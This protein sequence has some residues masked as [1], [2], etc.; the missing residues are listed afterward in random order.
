MDER[1]SRNPRAVALAALALVG[2][3]LA[4]AIAISRHK[5]DQAR[6]QSCRANLKYM[7]FALQFYTTDWDGRL[8]PAGKRDDEYYWVKPLFGPEAGESGRTD[9]FGMSINMADCPTVQDWRRKSL[10]PI[11]MPL[12][13]PG[14]SS[15]QVG[16]HWNPRIAGMPLAELAAHGTIL[17]YDCA[18]VHQGGRNCCFVDGHVK[19]LREEEFQRRLRET[20]AYEEQPGID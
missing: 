6:E 17:A 12:K 9:Y 14:G 2:L 16:Y 7:A 1:H 3:L 11:G 15:A 19:W 20:A 4:I 8:P 10:L 18:S 5:R 13:S